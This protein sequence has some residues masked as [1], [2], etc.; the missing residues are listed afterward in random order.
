[1]AKIVAVIA[2]LNVALFPT[3]AFATS[4]KCEAKHDVNWKGDS[5]IAGVPKA[6]VMRFDDQTGVLWMGQ[7]PKQ[8]SILHVVQKLHIDNALVASSE[9]TSGNYTG[10]EILRIRHEAGKSRLYFLYLSD[11]GA[12]S[13]QC[14]DI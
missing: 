9:V 2:I 8:P 3:V 12:I 11:D 1:M 14:H 13:G 10:N 5:L 7:N 4:Y 6:M